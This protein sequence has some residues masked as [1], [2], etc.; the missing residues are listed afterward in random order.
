MS[1]KPS[2]R[3]VRAV[4]PIDAAS[5]VIVRGGGADAEVVMGRRRPRSRFLPNIYVFPGGRLERADHALPPGVALRPEVAR[6][7]TRRCRSADPNALAMAVIRETFEETGLLLSMPVSGRRLDGCPD[8]ALWRAFV[9]AG[10]RPALEALDYVAR[11][12]TPTT[13]PQRFN[14]RFFAVD[15]RHA[16]GALEGDGELLDL[17]W[18][19]MREAARRLDVIDVTKFVLTRTAEHLARTPRER[20]QRPVP[21]LCKVKGVRRIFDE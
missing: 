9:A 6:K 17:Q 1:S 18:V 2:P 11:A 5:L 20:A 10:A 8:T 4:T 13:L 7:L 15:A 16:R 12:I 19:P 14:T 3:P 21:V